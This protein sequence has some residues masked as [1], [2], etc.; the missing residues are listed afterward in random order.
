MRTRAKQ[1]KEPENPRWWVKK[2]KKKP[3]TEPATKPTAEPTNNEEPT[4]TP[5]D[6]TATQIQE[7]EQTPVTTEPPETTAPVETTQ[8]SEAAQTENEA[9]NGSTRKTLNENLE[10]LYTSIKSAPN[11]SAKIEAFLRQYPLHSVNKRITKKK[12]PRRRVVARFPM[13]VW[14]ADLIEYPGLKWHNG[15]YKFV[16]LVVDVF[17]KMIYVEPMKRKLGE[18]TAEAMEKIL[19]QVE[20]SIWEHRN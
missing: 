5:Q 8:P 9:E 19:S 11:Y 6:P 7:T 15:N 3:T 2:R 13:D 4:Q 1:H 16:L 17:T 14:M 10:E 20:I 18:N 12:F